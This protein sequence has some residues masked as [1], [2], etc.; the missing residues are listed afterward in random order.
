MNHYI[1]CKGYKY[2]RVP[3]YKIS[4]DLFGIRV[5]LFKTGYTRRRVGAKMTTEKDWKFYEKLLT[6]PKC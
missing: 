3:N 5:R 6:K 4:F 2:V 1:W